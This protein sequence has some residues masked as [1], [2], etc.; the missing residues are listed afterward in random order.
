MSLVVQK[1][2]APYHIGPILIETPERRPFSVYRFKNFWGAL[3]LL[4][5][6]FRDKSLA[7]AEALYNDALKLHSIG[8]FPEAE[9]AYARCL[10]IYPQHEP[11][12]NN[13]A[14]LFI[15]QNSPEL[16]EAQLKRAID[17]RPRHFRPYYN[18]GLLLQFQ[19][20]KDAA[21]AAFEKALARRPRHFWSQVALAEL[22]E[23]QGRRT[24]ALEHFR[25]ALNYAPNAHAVHLRLAE[26]HCRAKEYQEA[27]EHLRAALGIRSSAEIHY[28]LG[29]VLAAR[30]A[31]PGEAAEM[32]R[33]ADRGR[34]NFKEALFN[35]ALTLAWQGKGTAAVA[36]M[37]QYVKTHEGK[38]A[39]FAQRLI[40]HLGLLLKVNPKTMPAYLR[41]A[42]LQLSAS[43]PLE[44][45]AILQQALEAEPDNQAV[46]LQ[47]AHTQQHMGRH[48][49]AIRSYR[50]LINIAPEEIGGY[51]GLAKAYSAIENYASALPVVKQA[52]AR[53]PNNAELHY[54]CATLL[55]QQGELTGAY[56][57]YKKTATLNP[58]FPRIQR[59]LKM[60]ED[61]L[62]D[63]ASPEFEPRPERRDAP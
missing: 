30:G 59:R 17:I 28:N 16:A 38:G 35:L 5:R 31:D 37:T 63:G 34:A 6:V 43:R 33:Q 23:E 55:A 58:D 2:L 22:H 60:L 9:N 62:D 42:E 36:K 18:L 15:Q 49:E 14:A 3:R 12:C 44:A 53:D 19:G 51:L 24:Q 25:Q 56:Q 29:W 41:I 21:I 10:T 48:K 20:R 52:L 50:K 11:A 8:R 1:L 4:W 40:E 26:I 39:S 46:L 45:L 27:E 32:F 54:H 13:L 7:A 57:H 61:E 47:L